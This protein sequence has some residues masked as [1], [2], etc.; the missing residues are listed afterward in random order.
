ME[1][2][3][4]QGRAYEMLGLTNRLLGN[5]KE[6]L[7]SSFK[8]LR[9]Y[10][11]L[12]LPIELAYIQLQVGEFYFEDE[13]YSRAIKYM[14]PSIVVFDSLNEFRSSALA[15][16]NLGEAYRK[17]EALDKAIELFE[18]AL[19]VAEHLDRERKI[20]QAYA[21]GNMGLALKEKEQTE[22]ALAKLNL[23]IELLTELG[24]PSGLSIYRAEKADILISKG[25]QKEGEQELLAALEMAR[26]ENLKKN[27]RDISKMLVE[28]YASTNKFN[29]AYEYQ[30][31]FQVYQ[32]SLVN[33]DNI[34][35]T[36]QIIHNY[37]MD[38]VLLSKQ[39][40]EAQVEKKKTELVYALVASILITGL[41][42]ALYAG[43]RRKQR[44]NRLLEEK[45]SVIHQQ[46]KEKELLHHEIHHRVK[47]NLQLISSIMGLQ[48]RDT[49]DSELSM[50]MSAGKSRV[51]AMTIIHQNLFMQEHKAS[52]NIQEYL[53]KLIENLNSTYD[54]QLGS[55][56][57]NS[58]DLDVTAD[59]AIPIGLIVNEAVCNSI[60]YCGL[61]F[62]EIEVAFVACEHGHKLVIKDNGTGCPPE[63]QEGS[64]F[65]TKLISTLSRQLKAKLEIRH[66]DEG[67]T[68]ELAMT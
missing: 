13:D 35:K 10:S 28:F 9:L 12:Q 16:I 14:E 68:V 7:K 23:A 30:Q 62:P 5:K 8:S 53:N 34:K 38:S 39:L 32:D 11:E 50:A 47:N 20:I 22:E 57:V 66:E 64:G 27:V 41:A 67:T 26:S 52:I 65:G 51:E 36:E 42:I 19:E 29:Q 49:E 43:Y 63:T 25:Q 17:N 40:V 31:L 55:I 54:G 24:D 59:E 48:S 37:Q 18:K 3:F 4:L 6:A 60:K 33:A 61:Q 2:T 15:S 58:I 21:S 44:S 1:N 56:S 45:N 46:V